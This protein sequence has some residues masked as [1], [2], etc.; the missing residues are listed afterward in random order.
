MPEIIMDL[1]DE[2]YEQEEEQRINEE[3]TRL[4]GSEIHLI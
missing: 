4:H 2:I 1:L 3:L